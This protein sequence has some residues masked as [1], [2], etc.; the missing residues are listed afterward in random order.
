MSIFSTIAEAKIQDWFSR[1]NSGEIEESEPL[2][3]SDNIKAAE[4]Y[5]LEDILQLIEQ[6]GFEDPEQ[7]AATL[8]KTREMEIQLLATLENEGYN[9]MAQMTADTILEH[10]KKHGPKG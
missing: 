6:A 7:R 1:K 3:T 5:L 4:T 9:L 8:K 10:R 2:T